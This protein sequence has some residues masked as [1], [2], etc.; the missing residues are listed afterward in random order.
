MKGGGVSFAGYPGPLWRIWEGNKCSHLYAKTKSRAFALNNAVAYISN[1]KENS[2]GKDRVVSTIHIVLSDKPFDTAALAG[3]NDP[4]RT[5]G[6]RL[7]RY[8][9]TE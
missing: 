6:P 5:M 8:G 9:E 4:T 7:A 3:D 2:M 1:A